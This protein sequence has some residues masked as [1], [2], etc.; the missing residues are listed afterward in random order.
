MIFSAG[1]IQKK[2]SLCEPSIKYITSCGIELL[3]KS[4]N[5]IKSSMIRKSVRAR[6]PKTQ[7]CVGR[8]EDQVDGKGLSRNIK[9]MFV[10]YLITNGNNNV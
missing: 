9:K 2:L 5:Y 1:D 8:N 10:S 6:K 7:V 3:K 4:M